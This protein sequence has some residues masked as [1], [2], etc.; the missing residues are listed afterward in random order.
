MIWHT[1]F[2]PGGIS[3]MGFVNHPPW[4]RA[5]IPSTNGHGTARGVSAVYQAVLGGQFIGGELLA[6]ACRPQSEG[7]DRV[8]GRPSCFGLGFQLPQESR[9]IGPNSATF[10]HFGYG[11]TL[12]MADPDANLALAYISNRPGSRWQTP[13]TLRMIDAFYACL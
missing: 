4:R 11:G 1:Y 8:L 13:R 12:G 6:E 5:E 10:G 7:E 3:G 2:N 9:P